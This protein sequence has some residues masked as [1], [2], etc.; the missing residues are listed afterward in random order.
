[1]KDQAEKTRSVSCPFCSGVNERG[2]RFCVHCGRQLSTERR[3]FFVSR[4][5]LF[6][7]LGLLLVAGVGVFWKGGVQAKWAA[8]GNGEGIAREDLFKRVEGAKKFYESRYGQE[9]FGGEAGKENLNR[10][11]T[12]MLDEM[13]TE[14]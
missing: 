10:L 11:K 12:Q 3:P 7:I 1:M 6:G 14:R 4:P 8:K 9:I 2:S 5:F 13:I